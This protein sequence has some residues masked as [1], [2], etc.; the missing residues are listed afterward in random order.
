VARFRSLLI[1]L[2]AAVL[3][4][5]SGVTV[6]HC[7]RGMGAGDALVVEIC[8]PE[9]MRSIRLDANGEPIADHAPGAEGGFCPVCH[10]LPGVTLPEPPRLATPAWFGT[11]VIWAMAPTAQLRPPA[12][13]PPYATRAPPVTA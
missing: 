10:S 12:R 3:L 11:S 9:G 13:A 5:Q 4:L 7:L 8:S 1:R 2:L 6:A